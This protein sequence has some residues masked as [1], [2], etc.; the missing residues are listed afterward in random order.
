[1]QLWF[2]MGMTATRPTP[3]LWRRATAV[4]GFTAS[5]A[6][7]AQIAIP[8]Y[9]VAITLQTW[10]VL[11]AG[12]VL[13]A[14]WGTASVVLY[15]VLAA[16]GLPVLANG[17]GG[18]ASVAGAS[19]GYL[20]GFPAA[21]F[22]AGWAAEQGRLDRPASGFAILLAAQLLTLAAGAGWLILSVGL[23]PARAV[24]VGA[25]PYLIGAVIKSALV[26]AVLWGWRRI[27]GTRA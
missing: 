6:L 2:G 27:A 26:L 21:A 24:Q 1:M 13:G 17:A 5:I 19:A 18:L 4:L 23:D 8:F 11:L 20:I 12:A 9:P 3:S 14:R 10:A 15:I 25:V 22:I 7:C 16:A